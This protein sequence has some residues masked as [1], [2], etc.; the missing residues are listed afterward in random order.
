MDVGYRLDR[1]RVTEA[2]AEDAPEAAADSAV[3][4]YTVADL[5]GDAELAQVVAV[6]TA[7][8]EAD[9]VFRQDNPPPINPTPPVE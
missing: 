2:G 3:V 1:Y 8:A 9:A 4:R 7:R 5:Q 6:L